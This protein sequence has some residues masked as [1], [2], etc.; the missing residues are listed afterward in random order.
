M[1]SL[2]M[3][4]Q[5]AIMKI[6]AEK[7]RIGLSFPHVAYNGLFNA[8]PVWFW[9]GGFW[10]GLLHLAYRETKDE[11]ILETIREL[12]RLQDANYDSYFSHMHHD[13]GFLSIPSAIAD[14]NASGNEEAKE[15][16][17]K[18]ATILAS[19]FNI[20]GSFIRA[21]NHKK[22]VGG[23]GE[24]IIDTM[25][26]LSL[27]YWASRVSDDPRFRHMA[28]SHATTV[29]E[30]SVRKD[31]T[32]PHITLF[33]AETGACL[34]TKGGQGKGPESSWSRGQAWAI[35]GFAISYRETHDL[36]FLSEAKEIARTYTS[37]LPKE[38]IPYWDFD[39]DEEDKWVFDSSSAC[40]AAS[41]V[42]ELYTLTGDLLF[43]DM[44][45]KLLTTLTDKYADFD[46]DKEGIIQ[47]GTVNYAKCKHI[48]VPIIYGDFFYLE[49]LGKLKGLPGLF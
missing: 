26:N 42:L 12:E 15:R 36:R 20:K 29:L 34:G 30:H 7:D 3:A 13:V 17:M 23:N 2:D 5:K 48:N 43:K 40:I 9:T 8:E 27:L 16:G 24:V 37:R 41:G 33:D 35:Y 49:A 31:H 1:D 10:P 14:Y 32:V 4:Y 28:H 21:W 19:R 45:V 11:Q 44:G 38:G 22:E 39:T 47:M 46:P 25:M 6:L 18:S